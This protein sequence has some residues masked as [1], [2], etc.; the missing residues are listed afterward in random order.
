M[1]A[2]RITKKLTRI[3]AYILAGLIVLL[4]GFHLWFINHAK[5]LL[6]DLVHDQSNG[7]LNLSIQKFHFNWFNRKLELQNAVFYSTD[8]LT[9]TTAYRFK[10]DRLKIQVKQI[11]PVILEKKFYIDSIHL[12]NPEIYVTKLRAKDTISTADTSLSIPQEMG[13]IYNSIQDALQVLK[14]DRFQIDN[15]TF[16]LANKIYPEEKPIVISR[17]YFHLDNLRV[18]SS[19]ADAEKKILFSDD[20]SL[21]T[22]NQDILFPDGRHRLSFSNFKINIRNR[23]AEFDS[24]TI[25]ATKGDSANT[26][27]RIFFD[28]LMMT[29]IN[30]DTL[31]HN[32]VIKADSVYCINPRFRLDV[33]LPERTGP[34]SPPKL[35]ELIQQLTGNMEL[36]FVIVQNGSF[37][38]NTMRAGR[39]S[40]FT[41][42]HNNF[43]LQGLRIQEDA[44]RPL[45]VE[46]FA[47][48]IHNYEN[49]LRDSAYAIQFDSILLNNNRISLSNFSYKE[50]KRNKVLNSLIMPQFELQGLSWDELIFDQQ[51]NAQGVTLYR[52]VITYNVGRNRRNPQDVFQVLKDIG[53][54]LQLNNLNIRDG[55]VNLYLGNNSTLKL[56]GATMSVAAKQ[57]T[58]SRKLLAI[59]RSVNELNFKKGT[60]KT[61]ALSASMENVQFKGT[62]NK[63]TAG[64]I[65]LDDKDRLQ[66]DANNVSINSMILPDGKQQNTFIKGIE[67]QQATVHLNSLPAPAGKAGGS[68]LIEGI[69]GTNT[70][71]TTVKEDRKL[72]VF[73]KTISADKFETKPGQH[74]NLAGFRAAGRDLNVTAAGT[75]IHIKNLA[76]A[77]KGSSSFQNISYERKTMTDSVLLNIPSLALVPDI[78]ALIQGNIEADAVKVSAPSVRINLFASGTAVKEKKPGTGNILLGSLLI[79]QPAIHFV[80]TNEKGSSAFEWEGKEGNNS[81]Q[82]NNFK[83]NTDNT[84]ISADQLVFSMDHFMY[85]TPG[86]RKFTAGNGRLTAQVNKLAFQKNETDNWDWQG[87]VARMNAENFVIDSLGRKNGTLNI[88]SGRL[89]D[90]SISSSLLLN[91]R[92]LVANNT[93]FNLENVTGSY[94]NESDQFRWYNAGYDKK[95]K[96]FMVDSFSYQPALSKEDFL[97]KRHYQADYMKANTGNISIGPFDIQRFVRDTILDMGVVNIHDGYMNSSRDKRMPR[98]AGVVKQLP[99]GLLKKIS[100]HVLADTVRVSNTTVDY[101]E[102]NEKTG[103]E[104]NISVTRLNGTFTHVRNFDLSPGDSLTIKVSGFLQDTLLTEVQVKQSYTD[105]LGG[106]L[107][108]GQMGPSDLRLLNPALASLASAELKSGQLDTMSMRVVGRDYLAFGEMKMF[109]HDLKVRVTRP[110]K[111]RTIFS[112][113]ATFFA[114]T[115]IKNENKS[116]TGTVFFIRWRDRSAINYLVKIA[117]NGMISSVGVKKNKKLIRKYEREIKSKNL[118]PVEL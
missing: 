9:A 33:D 45:T 15:A 91:M 29:N 60:F 76:I 44:P 34:I 80:N 79:E 108:T 38:I 46:R 16:S 117:L 61:P 77:D 83:V 92:D 20:V 71:L 66:L 67:W 103:I 104:G 55:Q 53:D 28:K 54:I 35:D 85:T 113:I 17:L 75:A 42:D 25:I 1:T 102:R 48:A 82:L 58:G 106:F 97:K 89:N 43:E 72:T 95:I 13:R 52:P 5:G 32:E 49:F 93:R 112:G 114:N 57:L 7:K 87:I 4:V 19:E 90:L 64:S 99:V 37:D 8:T 23:L 110:G 65:H 86:G 30:F 56:E 11:L 111:K 59:Q 69:R 12:S 74:P 115:L 2:K 68:L 50:L 24:C 27:F 100:T 14:V 31:Y 47:M 101:A 3:A 109:Y 36:A 21:H 70:D 78:N 6:E 22:T 62:E 51:L 88:V 116:R 118:P 107:M 84:A 98:E 105:S 41:S 10:I 94:L 26:S 63:L 81:F 73:F 39:P 96:H 40:S 18:D